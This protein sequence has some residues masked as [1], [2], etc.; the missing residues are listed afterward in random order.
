MPTV[1]T[2][3]SH[4]FSYQIIRK[5]DFQKYKRNLTTLVYKNIAS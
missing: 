2:F 3:S 5:C 4:E 1:G